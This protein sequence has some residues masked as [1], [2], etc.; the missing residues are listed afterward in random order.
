MKTNGIKIELMLLRTLAFLG[1]LNRERTGDLEVYLER[2]TRT[3]VDVDDLLSALERKRIVEIRGNPLRSDSLFV[4]TDLGE[5]LVA[6]KGG[7]VSP[8]HDPD[9][10][11]PEKWGVT[12]E[13]ACSIF[14]RRIADSASMI[15]GFEHESVEPVLKHCPL[16]FYIIGNEDGRRFLG[17][18][19]IVTRTR[20]DLYRDLTIM[21]DG[22]KRKGSITL[23][24]RQGKKLPISIV[25]LHV[26][27]H[28]RVVATRF[29]LNRVR[30]HR[31]R[32]S[33]VF[34]KFRLY[35]YDDRKSND[36]MGRPRRKTLGQV[37]AYRRL[38]Q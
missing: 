18:D 15:L 3:N 28:E 33:R 37:T 10:D 20:S 31:S 19:L 23:N 5:K 34:R 26:V 13:V 1:A 24:H 38:S 11:M 8:F 35:E 32:H 21:L 14:S 4:L 30:D 6:A 12:N 22:I 16:C 2:R 25:N 29:T 17:M 7:I 27:G 9:S 36:R